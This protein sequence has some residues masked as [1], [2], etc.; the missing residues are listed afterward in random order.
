MGLSWFSTPSPLEESFLKQDEVDILRSGD[1]M[2]GSKTGID[3]TVF[4]GGE[5]W[6]CV[7]VLVYHNGTLFA[8]DGDFISL[9]EFVSRYAS[10]VTRPVHCQRHVHFEKALLHAANRSIGMLARAGVVVPEARSS[11]I[12]ARVL[13][14]MDLLDEH[15]LAYP[16]MPLD[17]S[18]SSAKL[19]RYG[20]NR[21]FSADCRS[22]C[23]E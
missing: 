20:S 14:M 8:F 4:G 13:H 11:F 1:L 19:S 21:A 9:S 7:A 17:F 18:S 10:C 2:L 22:L 6:S 3:E 23:S 15:S 16:W 12:V 5:S